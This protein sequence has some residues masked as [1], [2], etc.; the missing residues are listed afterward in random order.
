MTYFTKGKFYND[1]PTLSAASQS[2]MEQQSAG[3]VE[4]K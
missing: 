2:L 4:E 3:S 1:D